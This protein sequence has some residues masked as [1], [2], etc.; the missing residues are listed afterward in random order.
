MG[1]VAKGRD[2]GVVPRGAVSGKLGLGLTVQRALTVFL[3]ETTVVAATRR[4]CK[5]DG[6]G[7]KMRGELGALALAV[8][9]HQW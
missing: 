7:E 6:P 2:R 3:P 4:N 1:F 5:R 8:E 9:W